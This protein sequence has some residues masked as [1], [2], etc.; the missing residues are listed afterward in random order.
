MD[1]QDTTFPR[2]ECSPPTGTRYNYLK[3]S[4]SPKPKYFFALDLHQNVPLLP[5]L[6]GSVVEA[7]R[8]LGPSNCALSIVEGRSTDGTFEILDLLSREISELGAL[9][10]L[11][12]STLNPTVGARISILAELRNLAL[13]PLTG[14]PEHYDKDTKVIFLN[15]VSICMEDILELIHQ[16]SAQGAD[17]VCAMDWTYAGEHPTFYDVWIARDMNGETFFNIPPDGNWNSA[18]NLFWANMETKARFEQH[19][20]FQVF[21]CWNGATVFDAAAV[22]TQQVGDGI[23]FRASRDGECFRGEPELFAK[24]LWAAGRGK[25]AVVPAVNLE[26]SDSD[27]KRIKALKGYTSSWIERDGKDEED[28]RIEW[29]AEPPREVKC[30]RGYENQHF[31]PWDDGLGNSTGRG[32][33]RIDG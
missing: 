28:G 26:Y 13:Q 23:K 16:Q 30:M 32:R 11:N 31:V 3:S 14:Y 22:L 4:K 6:L 33:S 2:L 24:D 27:A 25:I 18:W 17:M 20:P 10:H 15:D 29:R 8:F 5:R 7:T 21:S 9:Y 1:P 19:K 12:T